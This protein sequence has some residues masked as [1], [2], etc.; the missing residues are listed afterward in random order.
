MILNALEGKPLPVYG[1]GANVRDWLHVDDHCEALWQILQRGEPGEVYNIGGD[2][3]RT[4]LEVVETICQVV[5]ELCP[6]RPHRPTRQLV[7]FVPDRPGHDRR[8][9]IDAGKIQRELGWQ[10]RHDFDTGIRETVR[11]YL[12]HGDWVRH[13]C[14][15]TYQR[16]RLG[17]VTDMI[18]SFTPASQPA[19]TYVEGPI[20]GLTVRSL[21]P[22]ADQ[23]GWLIELFREDEL[24]DDLLPA[25]AYV[26]E[27]LP[28]VAR[29]PHEHVDQSDYFAF[30]GPGDFEL[31]A[32]DSRPDSP[33]YGHHVCLTVGEQNPCAVVVPPGVVHGYRNVGDKPGWVFNGPNRLY[34]GRGK[35][36]PVDE[37][38]HEDEAD[39]PYRM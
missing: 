30:V 29:G 27:T 19:S 13:V 9:A 5:D 20:D 35:Q 34:A 16:E 11:W 24:S 23:R 38:R 7:Q 21:K 3:E 26:S 10:P 4:N 15:G 28:G 6:D 39:S 1:D 32:W 33:T 12:D 36:E 31:H 8:Y 25:M 17:L 2:A 22:F 37:I 18:E 14:E